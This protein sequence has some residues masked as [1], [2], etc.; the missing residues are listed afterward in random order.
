MSAATAMNSCVVITMWEIESNTNGPTFCEAFHTVKPTVIAT[1]SVAPRWPKRSAAQIRAGKTTYMMGRLELLASS[2]PA[3]T[4][5]SRIAASGT[6]PLSQP[7]GGGWCQAIASGTRT[8]VPVR[9]P[10]H[11]VRH[12]VA[13]AGVSIT[14]PASCAS[15]PIVALTAVPAA[16]AASMRTIPRMVSSGEPLGTSRRS[17]IVATRTSSR[18]PP[19]WASAVPSG[20]AP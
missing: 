18:F 2:L 1:A 11:Q 10:N 5:T 9:S 16:N 12:T 20:S 8:S 7:R 6:R 13:S 19:V 3:I 14:P 17:R 4:R 15:E